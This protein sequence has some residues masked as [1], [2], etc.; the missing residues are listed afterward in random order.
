MKEYLCQTGD[1]LLLF[2]RDVLTE[3]DVK[4]LPFKIELKDLIL[5]AIIDNSFE[6]FDED[7]SILFLKE[8]VMPIAY[9]D[10]DLSKIDSFYSSL[11]GPC[12]QI[13]KEIPIEMRRNIL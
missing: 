5:R 2:M 10:I 4:K 3:N 11:T 6:S 7:M 8:F 9:R 13:M 1:G 12:V